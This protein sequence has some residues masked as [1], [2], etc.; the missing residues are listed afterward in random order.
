MEPFPLALERDPPNSQNSRRRFVRNSQGQ[1]DYPQRSC[2]I[3]VSAGNTPDTRRDGR[4][5]TWVHIGFYVNGFVWHY[6]NNSSVERVVKHEVDRELVVTSHTCSFLNRYTNYEGRDECSI[7]GGPTLWLADPPEDLRNTR[8]YQTYIVSLGL[9]PRPLRLLPGLP[10]GL[11]E[12]LQTRLNEN[13]PAPGADT[14]ARSRCDAR[15]A[16]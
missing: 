8:T 11:L 3:L 5:R 7:R 15:T 6:E 10:P 4:V 2:L 14:T 13:A 1:V 12:H 9:D 16:A